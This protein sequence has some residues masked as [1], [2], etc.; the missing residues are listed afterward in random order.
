MERDEIQYPGAAGQQAFVTLLRRGGT[1]FQQTL[2]DLGQQ[3][4]GQTAAQPF[5]GGIG[6]IEGRRACRSYC[7]KYQV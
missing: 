3:V 1:T 6:G 2:V 7:G 4:F 5:V